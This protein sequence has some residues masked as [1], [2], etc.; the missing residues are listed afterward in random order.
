MTH[1]H[2]DGALTWPVQAA[3][4]WTARWI[5][6]AGTA[7]SINVAFR[8][9]RCFSLSRAPES[10]LL[11]IAADTTY[12]LFI[13]GFE[14]GRGPARG[15]RTVR[16]FDSYEIAPF[17]REGENWIAA[18]VHCP[19]RQSFKAAPAQPG[20]LLQLDDGSVLTDE[21]WQVQVAPDWR[22][23]V[24]LF[25]F[26]IGHM[27]WHDLVRVPEGWATGHDRGQWDAAVCVGEDESLGGRSLLPRD[28]PPLRI[29]HHGPTAVPLV[30]SVGPLDDVHDTAIAERMTREPHLPWDAPAGFAADLLT[31][32]ASAVIDPPA[33]GRGV[34]FIVDFHR[35]VNG[36]FA[37]ELD[38]PAGTIMDVG[39]QED[40]D[41][42]R[43]HLM[44]RVYRFADRY[45]LKEGK[46]HV[47]N[48]FAERG[49]RVLQF[50]LHRFDRPIRIGRIT[51]TD[52]VYPYADRGAFRCSDAR[53][54]AVWDR[55]VATL[56]ACSTDTIVDC[57]WR[58]NTLYLNDMLVE[59]PT[60]LQAFGDPRLV[61]RCYRL[62]LSQAGDNGIL[63][64]AIPAGEIPDLDLLAANDRITFP[65]TSLWLAGMIEE[66]MLYTGDL[67]LTE[68]MIEPLNKILRTVSDWED[69][70]GLITPPARYWNFVDWSNEESEFDGHCTATLNWLHVEALDATARLM[71]Q[72]GHAPS[73][74]AAYTEKA[75]RLAETIDRRFW[76]AERGCYRERLKD[77]PD[78]ALSCQVAHAAAL[79][80]GRL[81]D[82]RR[83]DVAAAL[84]RE[85]LRTPELYLQHLVLRAMAQAGAPEAGLRR[86][87]RYW[88]PI[89]ET[90]SPTIWECGVHQHGNAAFQDAGSLCHGFAT[91]PI[92]FF[93]RVVLGVRPTGVGFASCRIDPNPVGL[94][95]AAGR[96]PTPRGEITVAWTLHAKGITLKIDLPAKTVAQLPDG[97]EVGPGSHELELPR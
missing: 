2:F 51:G 3:P 62:A 74:S 29:E 56:R 70:D 31:P 53:L 6:P 93:Q 96:V 63:P 75:A 83:D 18:A 52:R 15:T 10:K 33:D 91:T 1:C 60:S 45:I 81:P 73:D 42:G 21:T 23:D 39:Y 48:V 64:C 67:T 46:Q 37:I 30:A 76:M 85:D 55:C 24:S 97:R 25:T 90:G 43:L 4:E 89:V 20:L 86:I 22:R 71:D 92:D 88:C 77:K 8:A 59:Q 82:G 54:N 13:N 9:R 72:L 49:F 94:D 34:T 16:F 78:T 40:L 32:G 19:N 87:Q 14:L 79:L 61:A 28:I 47:E 38:A 57:P 69:D 41:D 27:E 65:A 11:H 36:G 68:Q 58:E 95:H 17:L 35:E 66:Y 7:D 26:Q 44:P 50:V 12:R 80:T 5:A 84:H